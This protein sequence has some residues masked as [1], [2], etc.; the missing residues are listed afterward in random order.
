MMPMTDNAA[1]DH[2]GSLRSNPQRED[3]SSWLQ[4]TEHGLGLSIKG[5]ELQCPRCGVRGHIDGGVYDLLDR[6]DTFYEGRYDSRTKYIPRN[7]GFLAT[8]PFR[9]VQQSYPNTIANLFAPGSAILDIGSAGGSDWFAKRYRMIGLDVSRHS[10]RHLAERYAM[11]V[12]A[13]AVHIP[14]ADETCDGAI[15]SCVFEHFTPADKA[16]ILAECHRVLRPGGHLVFF[17]DIETQNPVIARYRAADPEKYK[18]QFLDG[19]GHV[20]YEDI[21]ANRAH[22][23][24]AGFE[25]IGES[26][27]ECTPFLS[28]S[29]WQKLAQWPGGFGKAG[30]WG[31]ALTSG[32]L[33][34]PALAMTVVSDATL[35]ALMPK[36]YARCMTTV[37]R[38]R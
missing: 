17:Y 37:A 15:S 19:D 2:H 16:R 7:D 3:L 35:G 38:K 31:T 10:L 28:N 14:L 8:L 6:E 30:R 32:I 24:A 5:R 9:I 29:V 11:A 36:S 13:S 22:F 4:C 20:G 33:R 21:A 12:R 27:H 18:I 26:F 23:A 25:I 34:L 1:D